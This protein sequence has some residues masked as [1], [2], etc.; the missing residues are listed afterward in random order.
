MDGN[1]LAFVLNACQGFF[2]VPESHQLQN[3]DKKADIFEV[4]KN[5]YILKSHK[6][7]SL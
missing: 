2:G 7:M 5:I 6:E 3:C 1:L 4:S